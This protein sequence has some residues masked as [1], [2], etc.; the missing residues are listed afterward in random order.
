[1]QGKERLDNNIIAEESSVMEKL[2]LLHSSDWAQSHADDL[3][4]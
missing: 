1:M 3:K 2:V 4:M